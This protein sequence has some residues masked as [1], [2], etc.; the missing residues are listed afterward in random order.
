MRSW[1]TCAWISTGWMSW[2]KMSW[3]SIDA[4]DDGLTSETE[5]VDQIEISDDELDETRR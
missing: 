5:P 1:Q 4:D 2:T 3:K